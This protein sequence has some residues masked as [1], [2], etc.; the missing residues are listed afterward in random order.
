METGLQGLWF[1]SD[2]DS[3]KQKRLAWERQ[4]G[5]VTKIPGIENGPSKLQLAHLKGLF[6]LFIA[7]VSLSGLCLST[8]KLRS[9]IM[10]NKQGETKNFNERHVKF[11]EAVLLTNK[12]KSFL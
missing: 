3:L 2:L 4:T 10:K 12:L 6:Y 9:Y 8:E 5:N 7:G 1:Q 11:I